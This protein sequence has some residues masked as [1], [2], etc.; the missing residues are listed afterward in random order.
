MVEGLRSTP[1]AGHR[2][3]VARLAARVRADRDVDEVVRAGV[4]AV[5]QQLEADRCFVRL[6]SSEGQLVLAGEWR[7]PEHEAIGGRS[8]RLAVSNLAVREGRTIA[9]ADIATAPELDDPALGGRQALLELGSR[10]A[11]AV[12]LVAYEQVIGVVC[13]PPEHAGQLE[14]R[15]D[16]VRRS[17]RPRARR[18]AAHGGAPR[19]EREAAHA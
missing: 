12:P 13:R 8:A 18:R 17:R 11:L 16:R 1:P 14:G 10:A 19:R 4:E 9:I 6:G 15:G 3:T 5:G 7:R 2:A